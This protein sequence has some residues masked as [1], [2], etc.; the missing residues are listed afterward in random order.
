ME[1]AKESLFNS[2]SFVFL[3]ALRGSI[4]CKSVILYLYDSFAAI[5]YVLYPVPLPSKKSHKII[6]LDHSGG[7][8]Y[9]SVIL[10]MKSL[11]G[12]GCPNTAC[13]LHK[14][15][16]FLYFTGIPD[17]REDNCLIVR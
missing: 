3:R 7:L 16:C 2:L 4:L 11:E 5:L 1:I 6:A 13:F 10:R 9:K 8:C 12:D 17:I 14:V 15:I